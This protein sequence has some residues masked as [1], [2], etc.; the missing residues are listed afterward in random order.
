MPP[1]AQPVL[2]STVPTAI[3]S[4]AAYPPVTA[5]SIAGTPCGESPEQ[6]LDRLR[7]ERFALLIPIGKKIHLEAVADFVGRYEGVS[8]AAAK[9]KVLKGKG[10][11]YSELT[12]NDVVAMHPAVKLCRQSLV[13]VA[14]PRGLKSVEAVNVLKAERRDKGIKMTTEGAVRRMRW[15]EIRLVNC[16]LIGNELM[17][18]ISGGDPM[19]DFR[20]RA[21]SFDYAGFASS[22]S[23]NFQAAIVEFLEI[24]CAGAPKA[25]RSHIVEGLLQRKFTAP[26]PFSGW[27]EWDSYCDWVLYSH[28]AEKI[29]MEELVE[30][31]QTS[32][33]W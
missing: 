6:R 27:N 23:T 16:G 31:S 2:P 30:L 32:S 10:L 18:V 19:A 28:F 33:N 22:G 15:E 17:A 20:F 13:L 12:L 3:P 7:D 5:T 29:D 24:I 8:E 4:S 1:P 26:Q 11:L 9:K 21:S 14:I 25:V